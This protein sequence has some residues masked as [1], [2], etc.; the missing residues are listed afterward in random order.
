[1]LL[2]QLKAAYTTIQLWPGVRHLWSIANQDAE[3]N[4]LK[5]ALKKKK[6]LWNSEAAKGELH[7]TEGP[8]YMYL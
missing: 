4:A 3:H 6:Y 5:I 2:I 8:L 1:M 7:Y